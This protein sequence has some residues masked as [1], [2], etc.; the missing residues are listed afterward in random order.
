MIHIC[1][2]SLGSV[3]LLC[4]ASLSVHPCEVAS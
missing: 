4:L 1:E 3:I 2:G